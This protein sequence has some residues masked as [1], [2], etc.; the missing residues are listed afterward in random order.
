MVVLVAGVAAA[1]WVLARLGQALMK[2]LEGAAA[3][4]VVFLTTWLAVKAIS[5]VVRWTV[6][7]WRTSL[8][9]AAVVAWWR[10]LGLVSLL[11][12][13]ALVA[14]GLLAW[15][16]VNRT[17][18]EAWAGRYLRAWWQRWI[19]YAPRMPGWLRACGLTIPDRDPGITVQ[20]NPFRCT[21]VRPKPRPRRDELPRIVKVRAGGSWD[22][23]HV[24]L[25]PG[26]TPED[27]DQAAR[28][29]AVARGVARCQVR[30]LAPNQVSID[31]QRRDRLADLVPCADLQSLAAV[32]GEEVD[33]RRVWSGRTEYGTDWHQA[34]AGGHTL[35]AGSTGAGKNSH[36]WAPIVSIAP[37]IRDGLVHM[38]GIDPKGMELA[39]GRRI[40]HRYAVTSKDALALLDDLVD[41]MEARK[42]E[43]AGRVRVVPISHD[44]P[45]ELLEFDEIGALLRYV[46][47]RKTRE[48]LI[49]RVALL[50]TQGRALG[51]TVR[52]YVQEPTKDTVP[53][54]ELFPRRICLR[55]ASKAHVAMV[56]GDHAYDRGAWANRI[57]ESEAGVGYLFG[58]G[59][60]EPL[61]VRA[62]WVADETIKALEE[63]VTGSPERPVTA[64]VLP[65]PTP[66]TRP[67]GG[68][69]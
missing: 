43:F 54:R 18:F 6:R 30:E 37:A 61:R 68:V 46:G 53:V 49:D 40:F 69:A 26:Q 45:L 1:L 10:W 16:R 56:L 47:D 25:V 11:A 50:T 29:L 65:L 15:R 62:G 3:I 63:F 58:E 44:H 7:H 22:E 51:Y 4:A 33:L 66:M 2:L 60:R 38:S 57:G 55:V 59:I 36:S 23:V 64:P 27:F 5:R 9:I 8:A 41:G 32:R 48:A 31:Y 52:G 42:A 28:A 13:V 20:V 24:K 39:Y 14:V 35:A 12:A 19:I 67:V 17:A 21:A 34:L